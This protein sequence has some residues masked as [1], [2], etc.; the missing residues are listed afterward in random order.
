M[1]KAYSL[2][3]ILGLIS[4]DAIASSLLLHACGVKFGG[5]YGFLHFCTTSDAVRNRET[6]AV[7]NDETKDLQRRIAFLERELA[8]KQCIVQYPDTPTTPPLASTPPIP[9]EDPNIDEEAWNRRDLA[10]LE[11]CW[12]LDSPDRTRNEQ[13]GVITHYDKWHICFDESGAGTEEMLA[14]DGRTTCNGPVSG[15]FNEN[16]QLVIEEHANLP[17][18]NN[19]YIYRRIVSCTLGNDNTASCIS[20]TPDY[21]DGDNTSTAK[22]RRSVGGQ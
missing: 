12:D 17:C 14:T 3:L 8:S 5:T 20:T 2:L 1:I 19:T 21:D 9:E 7:L 13:T 22:F 15:L 4:V 6:L 16:G 10:V 18:S 11:G